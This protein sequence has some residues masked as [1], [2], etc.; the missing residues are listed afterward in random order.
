MRINIL[1]KHFV[2]VCPAVL[3]QSFILGK[4]YSLSLFLSYIFTA[5]KPRNAWLDGFRK[6]LFA[7]VGIALKLIP[8]PK[9]MVGK[10]YAHCFTSL[11]D[12][13]NILLIGVYR[14]FSDNNGSRNKDQIHRVCFRGIIVHPEEAL[15]LTERDHLYVFR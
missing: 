1:H 2:D 13:H 8:V 3:E 6:A 7:Q 9:S 10:T 11:L 14:N 12:E 5:S 4:G 15:E